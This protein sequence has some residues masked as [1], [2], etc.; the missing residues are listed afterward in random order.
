MKSI[1][2]QTLIEQNYVQACL[3][4]FT[5]R[6]VNKFEKLREE[7]IITDEEFKEWIDP[8]LFKQISTAIQ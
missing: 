5:I 4:H 2:D 8:D 7:G 1:A 3:P 6:V